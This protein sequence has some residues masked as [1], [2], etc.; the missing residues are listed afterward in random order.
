MSR[1]ALPA[2]ADPAEI[3]RLVSAQRLAGRGVG[4]MRQPRLHALLI[5]ISDYD[6]PEGGRPAE[7]ALTPLGSAALTVLRV[8]EWLKGFDGLAGRRMGWQ[9]VMAAPSHVEFERVEDRDALE[10]IRAPCRHADVLEALE[11]WRYEASRHRD[12][13]A[14]F[15]FAGHPSDGLRNP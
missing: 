1:S 8:Q 11:E 7:L 9:R 13:L 12:N 4:R 5:G 3:D 10:M 15:Y 2:A 14:F 6:V